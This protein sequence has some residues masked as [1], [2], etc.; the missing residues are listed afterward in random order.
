MTARIL[1]GKAL[2]A[3]LRFEAAAEAAEFRKRSGRSP[4]LV[5]FLVGEDPGS[6]IYVRSKAK[7]AGESG[8][9]ATTE[10]L[11]ET[12]READILSRIRRANEDA[13]T[14]GIL[15]QMPLPSAIDARRVLDTIDPMKDVDGFHPENAGL[16]VQGRPRF[17]PCTPAGILE[18][19]ERN[20]IPIVGK[21]AVVVGRSEIVGRPAAALLVKRDA[22]VM[23]AHSKTRDLAAVCREA[24]I[25]VAAI[26][27]PGFIG[28]DH[29][30]PGAT[31]IDVGIN[32]EDGKIR[33]DVDFEAVREIAGAL[34]PVPGG[35]G[36]LTVAM[37]LKNTAK[38]A[39]LRTV[40]C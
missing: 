11:P 21:R 23:I 40:A 15:V 2:A 9:E 33:G 19:L 8:I 16:L 7:A 26:G 22:T 32:R 6:A 5:V 30:S 35:V 29:V 28:K 31:V 25:L 10:T 38:A 3:E 34:S 27:R 17:V 24:E 12:I 37:L 4:R 14:D 13:R 39:A 20:K 36:P 1:D 18:L